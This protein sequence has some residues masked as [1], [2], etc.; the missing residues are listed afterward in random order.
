MSLQFPGKQAILERVGEEG[1]AV[2]SP[3]QEAS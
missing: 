2:A 3:S 1:R